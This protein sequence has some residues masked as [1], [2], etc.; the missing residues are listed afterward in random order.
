MS[1]INIYF[2]YADQVSIG[3]E[4][5][6]RRND[7]LIPGN[8]TNISSFMMQGNSYIKTNYLINKLNIT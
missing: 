6:V 5:L 7:E 2:R 8:V 3:D 1:K 4:V